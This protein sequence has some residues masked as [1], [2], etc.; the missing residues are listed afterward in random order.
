MWCIPR[1]FCFCPKTFCGAFGVA[2]QEAFSLLE[3]VI[4]CLMC[5]FPT[6]FPGSTLFLFFETASR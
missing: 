3:M 6:S 4:M 2:A 1:P 5:D